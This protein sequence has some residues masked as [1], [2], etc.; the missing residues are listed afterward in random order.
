MMRQTF[1]TAVVARPSEF[2]LAMT[3]YHEDRIS[4]MF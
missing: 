3:D 4:V 2:R 1:P